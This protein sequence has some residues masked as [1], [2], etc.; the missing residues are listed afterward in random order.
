VL[1]DPTSD[2]LR[3]MLD[4]TPTTPWELLYGDGKAGERIAG[5]VMAHILDRRTASRSAVSA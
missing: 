3:A 1:A 2:D 5:A 4:R